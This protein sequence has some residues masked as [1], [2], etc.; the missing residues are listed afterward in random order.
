MVMEEQITHK[1]ER[2]QRNPG[3]ATAEVREWAGQEEER[4][5]ARRPR[6]AEEDAA[7]AQTQA[8]QG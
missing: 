7:A 3:G 1:G 6:E 4:Q 5:G 8:K 2:G